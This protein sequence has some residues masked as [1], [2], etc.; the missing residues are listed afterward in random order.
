MLVG[1]LHAAAPEIPLLDAIRKTDRAAVRTLL[2]QTDVNSTEADGTTALHWATH[3]DDLETVQLLLQAGANVAAR[4]RFGSTPLGLACLNG[5]SAMIETLLKAGADVNATVG[6][7]E[8]PLMTAA[9]TGK[10]DAVKVLLNRGAN[11]N[12][13]EGWR[14]QTALMWAAAEGYAPVIRL[15]VEKGADLHARS[16][17]GFTPLLF[18]AREGK[19]DA[20]Q[21]LLALGADLNDALPVSRRNAAA[22][23][24]AVPEKGSNALLLAAGN[25]HYELAAILLD[26]GSDPNAAPQGWT[27]LHQI[28][29]VRK[30]GIA[31]SNDPAPEGSGNMTSLEFVR[32]LVAKGANVNSLVTKRPPAGVTELNMIGGTPLFLAART[33]DAELMQ[34]LV[35]LGADPSL[36]NADETTTLM[37]AAGVGTR[38]PG[39][40]PGTESEMVEAVKLALDLGN[41]VNSVD[42]NGETAMHGAAAKFAASIVQLLAA[43]GAKSQIWNQKNKKGYTPLNIAQGV[44]RG[45]NVVGHPATADAIRKALADDSLVR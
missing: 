36:R 27:A 45:M 8:T 23:P 39:E 31:G 21:T 41:N 37:A 38:A 34:L 13:K 18:A 33:A 20:V 40:D 5:N 29:W 10:L 4:N 17:G 30:A 35:D 7:G 25:A 26:R 3:L 44:Q 43:N 24:P 12:M 42:K 15:L 32:K 19:I 22:D 9:R 28:S 1:V 11:V 2:K 14:G 6:E 16:N